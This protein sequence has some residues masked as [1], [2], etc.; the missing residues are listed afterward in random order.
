M[1]L[2]RWF[3]DFLQHEKASGIILIAC[4]FFSLLIANS[5]IGESW[6]G[7]FHLQLFQFSLLE[8]IN[9]GLMT[10]FFLLIGLELKR[11]FIDGKLSHI[12]FAVL[13]V[14]AAFGG[15]IVPAFIYYALNKGTA[16]Q[17]GAG[18][19]MATDIAFSLGILSLLGNR[20]PLSLK[21]FLT[22]LAIIDDLGAIITIAAFYS[23][24]I[25][26]IYLSVAIL[27]WLI[28]LLANKYN[29]S[30][31]ILYIIGGILMWYCML[32]SGIH[33][34]ISGVLLAFAIP[35]KSIKNISLAESFYHQLDKPVAFFI[36]PL[37]ALANTSIPIP[38]HFSEHLISA[39]AIG[40]FLG[41]VIGKPLG[42]ILFT[43]L[44]QKIKIGKLP[45]D[46]NM[47]LIAGVG[48]L[49]GIGFTMSIFISLLA[50]DV[51]QLQD[52][53]KLA[54]IISS[55]IAAII[56]WGWFTIALR[57]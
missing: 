40:I 12:K 33:P 18:I 56:G 9:D 37:F 47:K 23:Q 35:F 43:Y 52:I 30:N 53:S 15:M 19:P 42:I 21:L 54:I 6:I 48:M 39:N 5:S 14:A 7:I 4:T 16:T 27:V 3:I 11:E 13:P 8:I 31:S 25:S 46:I 28:L 20:I 32:Q 29:F 36:V 45:D 44:A 26:L 50:F 49:G 51:P 34:T 57:K 55:A 17:S 2:Q 24:H 38:S 10:L 1:K 22:S 41:L